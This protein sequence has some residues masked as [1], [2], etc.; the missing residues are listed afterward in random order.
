MNSNQ[1]F[2]K[3]GP[4]PLKKIVEEINCTFNLSRKKS[5]F[6]VKAMK[7]SKARKDT[8]KAKRGSRKKTEE[9]FGSN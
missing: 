7:M 1:F 8:R 3:Q 5:N 6:E 4:I 9:L 2:N